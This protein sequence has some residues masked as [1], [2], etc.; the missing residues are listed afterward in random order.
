MKCAGFMLELDAANFVSF[1]FQQVMW[2]VT[3]KTFPWL[4]QNIAL[5]VKYRGQVKLSP[6][7]PL[8]FLSF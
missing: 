3:P 7:S 5:T 6:P 4:F 2:C 1:N 8:S